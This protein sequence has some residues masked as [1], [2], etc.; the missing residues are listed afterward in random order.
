MS[1]SNNTL[2]WVFITAWLFFGPFD[3]EAFNAEK[4]DP[5]I[6]PPSQSSEDNRKVIVWDNGYL[7]RRF[8][9]SRV[10]ESITQANG[11]PAA[12]GGQAFPSIVT[13][14]LDVIP[15]PPVNVLPNRSL[16]TGIHRGTSAR[17]AAALRLAETGR[18]SLQN[19]Q[20]RRAIYYLE[21]ALSVD[22]NP[23]I[24]FYLARAHYQVADFQG[25]L[26]FLE[27]AESGF[28]GQPEWVPEL[29][30]LRAALS[31]PVQQSVPKRNVAWTFNE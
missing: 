15:K 6:A 13:P 24:H 14:M 9:R 17:R 28:G 3:T 2:R 18:A 26:R 1:R 5:T 21:K 4:V 31:S 30:A 23:F 20:N 25:S 16:L 19:G 11:D 29:T 27:V 10:P 22:A 8:G 12:S 7:D